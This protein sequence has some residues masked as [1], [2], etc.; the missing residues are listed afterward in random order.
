M[1]VVSTDDLLPIRMLNEYAY[2]PRLFHFMQV[3]ELWTDNR[4]TMEGKAVH[5]RVD[6]REQ[7]LPEPVPIETGDEP[8]QVARSVSLGSERFGITGK[9]DLVET[10]D[11]EAIPVE[12]KRGRVP[13]NPERS[14]EPERVQLM[15]Q[16]LL[17]REHGYRC[18]QGVLY[19]AG[20]RTRVTVVFSSELEGRTLHLLEQAKLALHASDLPAPLVDSPK[21]NGCSLSGICL[22]DET[23]A[24]Q[25][26]PEDTTAPEIR[27][28]YPVRD[29]ALPLYL[30]EHGLVVGKTSKS[31]IIKQKGEVLQRVGLKDISQLVLCGN[32]TV[33]PSAIHLLCEAGIPI[34]HLSMG[35]WFYG[36]TQGI[37]LRNA[38]ARIAQYQAARSPDLALN[39]SRAFVFA[40]TQNQR[41]FLRRNATDLP[42]SA[43]TAMAKAIKRLDKANQLDTL[44]GLEGNVAR[45][46][47][48]HF[49][50]LLKPRDFDA[51]WD[52]QNRNRRP[53]RDPVNAMLSFGYALLVKECTVAL[54]AAGLDP[55]L[56]L[57]HQPRHGRPALA[58][59]LMEEF[60]AI[61]VDSA[62]VTAINTGMV[63]N[64]DFLIT[65]ASC[66]MKPAARKALIRAYENRLDQIITHPI[67][68][69]RCSYRA[70]IR[71]QAA[72][73]SRWLRQ[74]IPQYQG[75]LI[76]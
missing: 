54:L 56:G 59:D 7:P 20:S 4:Y 29:D 73:L 33:T 23:H 74:E 5:Q 17:L 26:I 28:L 51:C 11:A 71:V 22:P 35:H 30:Q 61:I 16:G 18:T 12:T 48:S 41:T 62:V 10:H 25:L 49:H 24:L 3:E 65:H 57:F 46:Y 60:R 66:A 13:D 47:F 1:N 72:L 75:I 14:W 34:V 52:Y 67:F 76:R 8:P 32:I 63:T 45:H 50:R 68:K 55:W 58:L 43:L 38:Y 40:K 53:P 21:C 27:R 69:Y 19:F 44:L 37:T 39:A 2:C 36:L 64:R 6:E 42:A 15:A 70:I 31:L 9:L